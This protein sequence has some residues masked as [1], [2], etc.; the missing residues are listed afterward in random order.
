MKITVTSQSSS[1]RIA[2]GV[3]LAVDYSKTYIE[4]VMIRNRQL[5]LVREGFIRQLQP[6]WY[7]DTMAIVRNQTMTESL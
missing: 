3:N 5:T 4:S 6:K 1:K 7:T 2:V